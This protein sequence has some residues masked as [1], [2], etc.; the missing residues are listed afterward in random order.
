MDS[1]KAFLAY[2][3]VPLAIGLASTCAC[4]YMDAS[5]LVAR[6]LFGLMLPAVIIASTALIAIH[7]HYGIKGVIDLHDRV[8]A[9]ISAERSLEAHL[10]RR[11]GCGLHL[12][13]VLL[14]ASR[15]LT[16]RDDDATKLALVLRWGAV[17][18]LAA[19]ARAW[20]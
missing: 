3:A 15:S 4:V 6:G 1:L 8:I 7:A 11:D 19:C 14:G 9:G 2:D 20:L 17:A 18:T 5:F 13:W 16:T 10:R 12:G